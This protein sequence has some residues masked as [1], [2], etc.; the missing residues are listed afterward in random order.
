M[1]QGTYLAAIPQELSVAPPRES[2]APY[3]YLLSGDAMIRVEVLTQHALV[4]LD[5]FLASQGRADCCQVS[6]Y[7]K[8]QVTNENR[9]TALV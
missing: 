9:A 7:K 8:V 1:S 6:C 3:M 4:A 5:V 2:P